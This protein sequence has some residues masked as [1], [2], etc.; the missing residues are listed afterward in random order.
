[1]HS[2]LYTNLIN[3]ITCRR[4]EASYSLAEEDLATSAHVLASLGGTL[5]GS[6]LEADHSLA[7]LKNFIRELTLA[8]LRGLGAEVWAAPFGVPVGLL[9]KSNIFNAS[10]MCLKYF[11]TL[12]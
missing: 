8:F 11:A 9:K 10:C 1:V 2:V 6:S 12:K 4:A 5:V 3:S 7:S